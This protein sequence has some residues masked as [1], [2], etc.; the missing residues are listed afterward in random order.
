NRPADRR[1]AD[2]LRP[3]FDVLMAGLK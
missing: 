2:L 1:A 3:V